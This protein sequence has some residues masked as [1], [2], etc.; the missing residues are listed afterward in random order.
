MNLQNLNLSILSDYYLNNIDDFTEYIKDF[1]PEELYPFYEKVLGTQ[2]VYNM[3][4][5][6]DDL[7]DLK[8]D[9]LDLQEEF[10]ALKSRYKIQNDLSRDEYYKLYLNAKEDLLGNLGIDKNDLNGLP[11][12][13]LTLEIITDLKDIDEMHS[14]TVARIINFNQSIELHYCKGVA[15]IE[16]GKRIEYNYWENEI[17]SCN[18][19]NLDI[20]NNAILDKLF[21]SFVE[22][23]G[24]RKYYWEYAPPSI[25]PAKLLGDG[26]NWVKDHEGG[27]YLESPDDEKYMY[28][29]LDTY[30][31]KINNE[32]GWDFL[33]INYYY[34]DGY[35][36]KDF[37]AFEYM[38]KEMLRYLKRKEQDFDI[39]V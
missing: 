34:L 38:E 15:T 26:W 28:F 30:E 23:F 7:Y 2:E 27:G 39:E 29:N 19:F 21:C 24:N 9:D 10:K 20:K 13:P 14:F 22:Y 37:D 17:V 16:Y 6:I 35:D 8:I 18:W 4:C 5:E 12:G 11:N 36:L 32:I 3:K 25:V 1:V 33:P 31:Y